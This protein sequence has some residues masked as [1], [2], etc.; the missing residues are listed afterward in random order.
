MKYYIIAG[1]ASGDLHASNLVRELA[2]QDK[3]A[4]FRG[5]GGELMRLQGVEM[6]KDYKDL[7]L[8]KLNGM[9]AYM[10]GKIKMSGDIALAMKFTNIF[11]V[12]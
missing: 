8:G 10:Q 7:A 5:W 9:T 1:E 2:K 11:K 4:V 3:E 6:V 12:P